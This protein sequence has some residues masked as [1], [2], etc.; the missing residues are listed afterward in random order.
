MRLCLSHSLPLQSHCGIYGCLGG[1]CEDGLKEIIGFYELEKLSTF[2]GSFNETIV[3]EFYSNIPK[4]IGKIG[5][6]FRWK[7][8]V[9]ERLVTFCP[10][11]LRDW[12]GM[13]E[14]SEES[15]EKLT[16]DV[17]SIELAGKA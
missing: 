10:S 15:N 9:R 8:Y 13:D 17:V 12:L 2:K 6:P 1:F 3:K 16:T 7:T 11:I 5:N 4:T 14:V